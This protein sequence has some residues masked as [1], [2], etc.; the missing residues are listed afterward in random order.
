MRT[1]G[2]GFGDEATWGG[3]LPY[4]EMA[5]AR[6]AEVQAIYLNNL[7]DMMTGGFGIQDLRDVIDELEMMPGNTG[8]C[9]ATVIFG[10]MLARR[11]M[12]HLPG[13]FFEALE[14]VAYKRANNDV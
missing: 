2:L 14:A 13:I 8:D 7:S 5:E 12:T 4:D 6:E 3:R 10:S 1:T 11:G 9:V